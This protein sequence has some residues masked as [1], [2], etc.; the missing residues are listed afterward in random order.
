MS[1]DRDTPSKTTDAGRATSRLREANRWPT[2][3]FRVC[4]RSSSTTLPAVGDACTL[5]ICPL[6]DR[7]PLT[8]KIYKNVVCVVCRVACRFVGDA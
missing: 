8:G 4:L 1:V 5:V 2:S 3:H 7:G 6:H